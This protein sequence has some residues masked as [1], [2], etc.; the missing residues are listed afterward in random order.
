MKSKNIKLLIKQLKIYFK[1]IFL[2]TNNLKS[3]QN[4]SFKFNIVF[5]KGFRGFITKFIS[6]IKF[7]VRDK[8]NNIDLAKKQTIYFF[9]RYPCNGGLLL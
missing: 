4:C 5:V 3:R 6:S 8:E 1:L 9:N 7:E 2:L